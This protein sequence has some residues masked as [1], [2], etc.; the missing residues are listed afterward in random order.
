MHF[1]SKM[2]IFWRNK[3]SQKKLL[4][5]QNF[6]EFLLFFL[7]IIIFFRYD[8]TYST[9]SQ[10]L[11]KMEINFIDICGRSYTLNLHENAK[12]SD[13]CQL[14]SQKIGINQNQI[15]LVSADEDRLFYQNSE[16]MLDI[17]KENPDFIHFMKHMN[18]S[19]HNVYENI[20]QISEPS[21]KIPQ[22]TFFDALQY[23]QNWQY[24]D[25]YDEYS[26]VV[27]DMPD[28]FQERVNQIAEL[29]YK[30]EDIKEALRTTNY[31][32]MIATHLLVLVTNHQFDFIDDSDSEYESMDDSDIEIEYINNLEDKQISNDDKEKQNDNKTKMDDDKQNDKIENYDDKQKNNDDELL[33]QKQNEIAKNQKDSEK[34]DTANNKPIIVSSSEDD[35]ESI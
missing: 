24:T 3:Y 33:F 9:L 16:S 26:T 21:I 15:F 14:L 25:I 7:S 6:F 23:M 32:V 20:K 10:I 30:I 2:W 29:G 13:A 35:H 4:L 5:N 31:D 34:L 12:V 8:I 19:N 27:N 17:S 28:D 1:D 11:P 22:E 18:T